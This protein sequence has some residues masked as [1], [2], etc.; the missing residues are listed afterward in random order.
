[1]RY[2]NQFH[3]FSKDSSDGSNFFEI[4]ETNENKYENLGFKSECHVFFE[5]RK[6]RF[7][8]FFYFYVPSNKLFIYFL[9]IN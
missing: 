1:M 8:L 6:G 7:T 4:S 9:T 5:K 3:L 2:H